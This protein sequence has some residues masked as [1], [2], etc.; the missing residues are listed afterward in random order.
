MPAVRRRLLNLLTALS[1]L[2]CVA[3]CVLWM[4]SYSAR[5]QW[6]YRWRDVSADA[7]TFG[8]CSLDSL[9]GQ[10]WFGYWW[11]DN[12]YL[13]RPHEGLSAEA[14]HVG[15]VQ[16]S[17][18]HFPRPDA[19]RP[20]VWR[21]GFGWT[22]QGTSRTDGGRGVIVPHWLLLMLLA[23]PAA[24]AL[25]RRRRRSACRATAVCMRCGYDLRATPDRCPECGTSAAAG[26]P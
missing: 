7:D 25:A 16:Q 5:D 9:G 4:R 24:L 6:A 22:R 20:L 2:L 12:S 11:Q 21:F 17:A 8:A 15:S 26:R 14:W 13:R 18:P 19:V 1:L 10:L 23:A 3:A